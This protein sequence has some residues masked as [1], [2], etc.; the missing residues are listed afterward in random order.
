MQKVSANPVP[1]LFK[2]PHQTK[3]WGKSRANTTKEF[4]MAFRSKVNFYPKVHWK[5][6]SEVTVSRSGN[7]NNGGHVFQSVRK[8]RFDNNGVWRK[9]Y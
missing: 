3:L 6:C 8:I 5:V 4:V 9:M 1:N 7:V 2:G